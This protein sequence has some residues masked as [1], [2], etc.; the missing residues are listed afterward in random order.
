[1][2]PVR[3]RSPSL[4]T[5]PAGTSLAPRP[6]EA[7][8]TSPENALSTRYLGLQLA[9]PFVAGASP[10]GDNLDTIR[11]LEDA[12]CAAIVLHSLFEEQISESESGRVHRMDRLDS[13]FASVLAHFP[14]PDAY[15]FNP[16][17][18][19]EHIRKLKA[20]VAIPVIASLN[21]TSPER[22][23]KF[24]ARIEEAG[25]DALELN[26]YEVIADANQSAAGVERAHR[27]MVEDL[28]RLVKMPVAVK[29]SPFFT[30]FA[31][32]ARG[33]EQAGADGL[34]IFNRFMQPDIDLQ[35]LAVWPRL[36]LSDSSEL[37]LRL[38]WL[39]ILRGQ[40]RCSLAAVGGIATPADAIK[41]L[42]AGADVVQVVSAILRHGPS[43]FASMRDELLR[44]MDALGF[45]SLGDVRGRL[46]L[47][48]ADAPEAFERG[49][50][51]QTLGGWSSWLAYET[52]MRAR[53]SGRGDPEA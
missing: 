35:H 44:W 26:V 6:A 36:E 12:G 31:N 24:A 7:G 41:A 25:A 23:L 32:V 18:Y 21:G 37:L 15:V 16:E 3:R 28:K 53:P 40:L 8:V 5:H 19:L 29:V 9:N 45:A 13:G 48:A 52:A 49:H 10:L 27:L 20:S 42:L 50:Y 51:L 39:A 43:Y 22:W 34:V 38:R 33:L 14:E 11:R 1:M 2:P 30:A 4:R 46:S 47:S 17:G